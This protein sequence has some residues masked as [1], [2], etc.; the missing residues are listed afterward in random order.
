MSINKMDSSNPTQTNKTIDPVNYSYLTVSIIVLIICYYFLQSTQSK[1]HEKIVIDNDNQKK[2]IKVQ[3][4]NGEIYMDPNIFEMHMT[5]MKNNIIELQKNLSYKDCN[6]LK[7]YVDNIK[8]NTNSYIDIN[9]NSSSDFCDIHSRTDLIDDYILQ[10]RDILKKK[11]ESNAETTLDNTSP[12]NIKHSILELVVDIDIILLLV[13]SSL[14]KNGKLDLSSIDNLILELYNKKCINKPNYVQ[15]TNDNYELKLEPDTDIER[16]INNHNN[17][18]EVP[19]KQFDGSQDLINDFD[20]LPNNNHNFIYNNPHNRR[21]TR[22]YVSHSTS[23][24]FG[25]NV[26]NTMSTFRPLKQNLNTSNEL[27][28]SVRQLYNRDLIDTTSRTSLI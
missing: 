17:Y 10:E 18:V 4:A 25:L 7:Q 1:L 15:K 8:K 26:P 16:F 22:K 2:T 3:T 27:N 9:T 13:R 11:L 5:R 21:A 6:E 20:D 23:D 14:C 24:D 28:S 12:D 19:F